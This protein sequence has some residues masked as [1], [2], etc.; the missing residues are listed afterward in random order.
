VPPEAIPY[1]RD[2]RS[3]ARL[4][5]AFPAMVRRTNVI[6]FPLRLSW[7]RCDFLRIMDHGPAHAQVVTSH[8]LFRL[9]L[10]TEIKFNII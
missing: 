2:D 1:P 9:N 3:P 4:P 5:G 6:T 10:L 7:S 8:W